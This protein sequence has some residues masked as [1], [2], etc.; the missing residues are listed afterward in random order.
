MSYTIYWYF[1]IRPMSAKKEVKCMIKEKFAYLFGGKYSRLLGRDDVIR[2][3]RP[4]DSET[5]I[6]EIQED[7]RRLAFYTREK[8]KE[9]CRLTKLPIITD[10]TSI[11]SEEYISAEKIKSYAELMDDL[12][13]SLIAAMPKLYDTRESV[14]SSGFIP[15]K[16]SFFSKG[17]KAYNEAVLFAIQY[18]VLE[19]ILALHIESCD[20]LIEKYTRQNYTIKIE[21]MQTVKFDLDEEYTEKIQKNKQLACR[22]VFTFL[23]TVTPKTKRNGNITVIIHSGS[24]SPV[25]QLKVRQG[26]SLRKTQLDYLNKLIAGDPVRFNLDCN[27]SGVLELK[28]DVKK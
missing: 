9:E 17:I 27:V 13:R 21:T 24:S 18:R 12:R 6:S 28:T 25:R 23:R 20:Q 10:T 11:E 3:F 4:D 15:V 8:E 5:D 16:R 1:G 14:N 7:V 2:L 19:Q 26:Y 22:L